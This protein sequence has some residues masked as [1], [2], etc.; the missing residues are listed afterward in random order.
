MITIKNSQ[1]KVKVDTKQ[2]EKQARII[3]DALEYPDY[4]LGILLITPDKIHELNRKYRRKNKPTDI[5]S[6]PYHSNIKAGQRIKA[7]YEE[8][9]NLG[10]LV[11]SPEYVVNDLPRWEQTFEQRLKVLLV[12]GICHLLG[13]D[14]IKDED[15]KI[16][17]KIEDKL[18]K[19][20]L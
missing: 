2:L 6:F 18:L 5:L 19:L 15:Y 9:N 3:L 16:M 17:K 20:L 8:D 7:C 1:R 14:H 10:D 12:H 4:D 11:I 13:Y